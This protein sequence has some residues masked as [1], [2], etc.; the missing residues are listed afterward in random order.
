M[1]TEAQTANQI[2]E[3]LEQNR[4]CCMEA[5]RANAHLLEAHKTWSVDGQMGLAAAF[6]YLHLTGDWKLADGRTLRFKGDLGGLGVAGG[7]FWGKATFDVDL[8]ELVKGGVF[9]E[10]SGTGIVGGGMQA[11]FWRDGKYLGVFIGAGVS[12]FSQIGAGSGQFTVS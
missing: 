6:F 11:T 1:A 5:A 12:I 9:V 3:L 8:D 10:V 2:E 4:Q 7:S